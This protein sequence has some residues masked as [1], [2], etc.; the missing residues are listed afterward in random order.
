V[1]FSV[2]CPVEEADE[3][4][5]ADSEDGKDP[6]PKSR[7]VKKG[8]RSR[9]NTRVDEEATTPRETDYNQLGVGMNKPSTNGKKGG[10][11]RANT[12]VEEETTTPRETDYN[13]L[14]VGMNKPSSND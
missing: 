9:A 6:T 2:A 13:Q 3:D 1:R 12:R 5:L 4:S 14:G 7:H 10:R 8:G 11:S